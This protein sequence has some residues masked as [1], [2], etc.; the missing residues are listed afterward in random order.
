MRSG[1]SR[2]G[3]TIIELL[4]AIIVIFVL[5][6]LLLVAVSSAREAARRAQC[7]NNLRQLALALNGYAN[8]YGV[9]PQTHNGRG[10]SPHV[11]MLP[12]LEQTAA[13][14]AINFSDRS[15]ELASK[16]NQTVSMTS[17][18]VFQCPTDYLN[19]LPNGMTNYAGN[20]GYGYGESGAAANNGLFTQPRR[21][22]SVSVSGVTDGTSSTVAF[23]E[24]LVGPG[25]FRIVDEYRSVFVANP[26]TDE[27]MPL[28]QFVPQ[29]RT[30][31][32]HEAE[33][34]PIPKGRAWMFGDSGHTIY[35][36]NMKVNERSCTNG[37]LVQQGSWSA[38][39][40]HRG[41][42]FSAF[43]DGHV[44]FVKQTVELSTWRALGSRNGG[45]SVD[46]L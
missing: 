45:E 7:S 8:A 28:D 26:P 27:M 13:Y 6:G 24:W 2:R 40:L 43:A 10:Y 31:N 19:H 30:L 9:Y 22:G 33:R 20:R 16:S 21:S 29:C 34:T 35:N 32:I 36:H 12:Y 38:G 17:L 23:S 3:F 5:T 44:R 46:D 39:S 18:S 11:V 41:G 15:G 42:A 1:A 4:V 37:G 14:A 25:E